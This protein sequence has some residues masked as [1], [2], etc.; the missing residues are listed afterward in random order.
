MPAGGRKLRIAVSIRAIAADRL[1]D[2]IVKAAA[3]SASCRSL[4]ACGCYLIP[5]ATVSLE[6]LFDQPSKL[7][8]VPKVVQQLIQSLGRTDVATNAIAAQLDADPVLSAKILRLAN[9]AYFRASRSVASVQDAVQMLGFGM[10]RNLVMGFGLVGAFKSAADMDMAGFWRYSLNTACTARWLAQIADQ[11]RD[12]AF[13]V[14]LFHGLGH[15]VM[16]S[17]LRA[18]M[19]QLDAEV[20]PLALGRAD[21]EKA[22]LGYHHGEVSAELARCW[23]FPASIVDPLRQVPDPLR[24]S[25]LQAMAGWVHVASWRARVELF[26]WDTEQ[27]LATCPTRVGQALHLPF[28]WLADEATLVGVDSTRMTPMPPMAKLVEGLE[29]LLA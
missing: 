11:D 8:V 2:R 18:D 19:Q 28:V 13:T 24:E 3:A 6:S 25:P 21:A 15:L 10:V 29:P 4:P 23:N 16:H 12:L 20:N 27:I 9:S 1:P 7:P 5:G 14:G 17:A 22:K 26:S